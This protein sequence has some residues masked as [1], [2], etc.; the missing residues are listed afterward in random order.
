[1]EKEEV[2]RDTTQVKTRQLVRLKDVDRGMD[3]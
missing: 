1:M 2:N 3:P